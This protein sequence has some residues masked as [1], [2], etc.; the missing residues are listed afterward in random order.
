MPKHPV[1]RFAAR[2]FY[3]KSRYDRGSFIIWASPVS[4]SVNCFA[5][6]KPLVR[7]QRRVIALVSESISQLQASPVIQF[8]NIFLGV[9]SQGE[10]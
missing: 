2:F 8:E 6:N 5:S 7:L 4:E 3:K 1:S 10:W 9:G